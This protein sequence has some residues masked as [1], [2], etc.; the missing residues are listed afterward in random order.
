MIA[1]SFGDARRMEKFGKSKIP[2]T[3]P[4]LGENDEYAPVAEGKAPQRATTRLSP[5][6]P[7]DRPRS[8]QRP[9]TDHHATLIHIP[10][11]DHY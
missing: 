7:F 3:G 4:N 9:T 10:R 5:S 1:R 6:D 8:V 2:R 11:T